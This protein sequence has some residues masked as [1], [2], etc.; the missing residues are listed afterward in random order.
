MLNILLLASYSM[1]EERNISNLLDILY[2][3][4][5]SLLILIAGNSFNDFSYDGWVSRKKE[6]R[7]KQLNRQNNKAD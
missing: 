3:Y 7:A 5:F 6:K 1:T 4:H 2:W